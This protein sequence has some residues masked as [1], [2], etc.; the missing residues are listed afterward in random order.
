[1]LTLIGTLLVI[2]LCGCKSKVEEDEISDKPISI[3]Q[4]KLLD[5]AFETAS[6][7]PV[8]PHIKDR[9][10]AQEDVIETCL[11]LDQPKQ[12]LAYVEKIENWRRGLCYANLAFYCAR[13]NYKKEANKYLKFAEEISKDD[14]GQ[15]WRNNRIK[16]IIAKTRA[17]LGQNKE[18]NVIKEDLANSQIDKLAQV[19]AKI[20][21][22]ATFD[23][24]VTVL[25]GLIETG[26]YS[27]ITSALKAYTR[28]YNKFYQGEK[29]RLLAEDKIK[30]SWEKV[31]V[32][33]RIALL[34]DLADF[35][36]GHSD[37]NKALELVNQAQILMDDSQW[38][39]E[40]KI[41]LVAKISELRHKAGD[42]GRA[43]IDADA[44]LVLF[45]DQKS[46]IVDIYRAQTLQLLGQ[47]Y[48]FMGDTKTALAVYKLAIEESVINPNSRPRAKDLSAICCSMALHA[49]EPD[50][51][52]WMR[53]NR[54]SKELGQPW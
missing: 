51:E 25:D 47:A 32:F 30:T 13:Q 48:Q 7:I 19:E 34:L 39:L 54:I 43:K 17:E 3:F 31:P 21:P 40:H 10:K 52:L 33:I 35:S 42:V 50:S 53:I 24:Q 44:V 23:E 38:R 26:D 37:Q 6:A 14:H 41:G 16:T 28:L 36:L 46:E 9:S 4:E 49:V 18:A 27:M 2:V 45:N 11:R 15:E 20:S 22:E 8:N 12:V 1:L 29:Q 5:I